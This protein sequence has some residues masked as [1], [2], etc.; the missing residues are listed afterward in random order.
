M[1][2]QFDNDEDVEVLRHQRR[3]QRSVN[4]YLRRAMKFFQKH[5]DELF[6]ELCNTDCTD[7]TDQEAVNAM[8]K[9]WTLGEFSC[10][11]RDYN[12]VVERCLEALGKAN[13]IDHS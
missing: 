11:P 4:K 1:T 7:F 3:A 2:T 10:G 9:L 6:L 12:F 5:N 13:P 8:E